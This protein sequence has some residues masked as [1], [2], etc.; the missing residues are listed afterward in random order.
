MIQYSSDNIHRIF[1]LTYILIFVE[2]NIDSC[3]RLI[4]LRKKT[5]I[6]QN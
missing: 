6:F 3:P 4:F 2:I 1:P 5:K